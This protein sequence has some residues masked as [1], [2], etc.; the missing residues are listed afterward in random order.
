MSVVTNYST[1][2]TEIANILNRSDLTS[3][4]PGFIQRAEGRLKRDKRIKKIQNNISFQVSADN[5][6]LPSD[7]KSI[8]NLYIDDDNRRGPIEIVTAEK[9]STLKAKHG[10]TGIPSYAA[11]VD[12]T[13]RMAPVPDGTYT[14]LLT[15]KRK[16]TTL[17]DSS[18]SNWLLDEWPDIYIYAALIESA[19]F[20]KDDARIAAWKTEYVERLEELAEYNDELQWGGRLI[21]R[22]A[23]AL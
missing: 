13:L 5:A 16:V 15:Y 3:S 1:L 8:E 19:P 18:T 20:L 10:P 9:L 4:I 6:T 7:L 2:K 17:S 22:P 12:G 23:Q 14:L 11:V 21:A